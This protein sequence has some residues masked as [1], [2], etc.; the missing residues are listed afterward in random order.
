MTNRLLLPWF[1]ALG[2]TV[3]VGLYWNVWATDRY[4]SRTTVVLESP[5]IA[6]PELSFSS[7][8]GGGA[9]GNTGDLLMLREY[10]RSVDMLRKVTNE[11]PFRAHYSDR[12]DFFT[13]LRDADAP[14]E[15]LHD[16]Y[17]RRVSIEMDD[18]AGVL[19]ISVQA[20]D[21]EFAQRLAQLLL[22][23]GE[24][25]MNDMGQRLAEEQV[26]FLEDQ[27]ERVR[28]RLTTARNDLLE[29]Q[30]QEGLVS[31]TQ[32][33]ESLNQVVATLE[34]ELAR[35]EAREKAIASYQ[36]EQS[37]EMIRVRSE[38]E[39]LREQVRVERDRLA[40]AAGDSLNEVSARYQTLEL[41][42]EFAQKT[43]SSALAA[44]QNTRIEAARKLKQISVL[45]SPVLAE[46]S[47]KPERQRNTL[48]FG[49]LAL[50]GAVIAHMLILIIRDH[51]D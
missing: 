15:T 29:F 23:A 27:V 16:Y 40:R 10:L 34:G 2:L 45:Q 5:Q 33:V 26:K 3:I 47:I 51:R 50:I 31:P 43:F 48:I 19:N 30:N 20:F 7:L 21:P 1:I 44:L 6:P 28:G 17:L 11:L 12:G 41:R 25:H 8:L 24:A 39:A 35:L 42:A 22:D 38:I 46:Y 4:V 36:S 37:A 14:I 9:G 49:L 13:R 18:Y 32:T